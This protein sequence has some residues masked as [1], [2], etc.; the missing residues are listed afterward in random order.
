MDLTKLA[1]F[2][3]AK[4]RMDWG[5]Q[6]MKVLSE[7]IANANTPRYHARDVKELNFRNLALSE[8]RRVAQARTQPGHQSP[9]I[10]E[11][12]PYRVYTDRYPY[13]ASPDGNQVILEEQMREMGSTKS[14]YSLALSLVKKNLDML[15]A[16][17]KTK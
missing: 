8:E 16:A 4:M 2:Q 15:R 5:A 11:P 9:G 1:F 3:M 10:P 7:N 12:G 17:A 6:R 13:E 14:E